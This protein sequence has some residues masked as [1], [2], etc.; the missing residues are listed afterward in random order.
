MK[1][2]LYAAV[3]M[4]FQD[5]LE[6]AKAQ[7]AARNNGKVVAIADT[8]Y[9]YVL[10]AGTTI[11]AFTLHGNST[12]SKVFLL[13]FVTAANI[14]GNLTGTWLGKKFIKD[15]QAETHHKI[16]EELVKKVKQLEEKL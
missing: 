9:Y 8:L 5:I 4:F 3:C 1:V 2:A 13:S 16:L 6:I 14:A 15:E 12:A 11:A 10:I 7:G